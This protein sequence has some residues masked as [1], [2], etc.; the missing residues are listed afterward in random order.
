MTIQK[1]RRGSISHR[2]CNFYFYECGFCLGC[3]L[4]I[5]VIIRHDVSVGV[6]L[7]LSYLF[8]LTN[9]LRE[10]LITHLTT[11]C[12]LSMECMCGILTFVMGKGGPVLLAV[13]HLLHHHQAS[14]LHIHRQSVLL[15]FSYLCQFCQVNVQLYL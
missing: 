4:I 8:L 14:S 2:K 13:F 9:F 1:K 3:H 7:P 6:L 15:T 5:K 12:L 10:T 11:V